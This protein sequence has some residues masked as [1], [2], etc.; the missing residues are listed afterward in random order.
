M[1]RGIVEQKAAA[2]G[3]A[4]GRVT[5]FLFSSRKHYFFIPLDIF[6]DS[7]I[8]NNVNAVCLDLM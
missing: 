4:P 8:F 5:A 3:K 7:G 1:K 2:Q 6:Q